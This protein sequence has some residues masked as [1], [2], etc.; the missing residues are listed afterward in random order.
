[1]SAEAKTSAGSPFCIL[2]RKRPEGPN[3]G[4]AATPVE[5]KTFSMSVKA[6][7]KLP[8][9]KTRK[10]SAARASGVAINDAHIK[11]A[12]MRVSILTL[13][14]DVAETLY[15]RIHSVSSKA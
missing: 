10:G 13:P 9:A 2:S 4:I 5:A 15:V 6:A 7:V 12:A 8:A 14:S 3:V 1:M 11:I